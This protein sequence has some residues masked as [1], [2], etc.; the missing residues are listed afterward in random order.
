MGEHDDLLPDFIAECAEAIDAFDAELLL[1]EKEPH[2]HELLNSIFRRVH[3]IKGMCGFLHLHNLEALTHAAEDLL[4]DLRDGTVQFDAT[5]INL[6]LKTG[7]SIRRILAHVQNTSREGENT[8]QPLIESLRLLSPRAQTHV[9]DSAVSSPVSQAPSTSTPSTSP[10]TTAARAEFS[11]TSLRVD[12]A[13]LDHLMNLAGELVLARNQLLQTTKL[14]D[15]SSFRTIVQR[16]HVVTSELQEGVMKTR[17]QPLSSL[18]DRFPRVA[19]D[20]AQTLNKSVQLTLS[21]EHTEVDKSILEALKDPLVHLLRNAIDHGI[22]TPEVRVLRDKPS[23]G[24]ISLRAYPDGGYVIIEVSDDGAGLDTGKI[25]EQ[26]IARGLLDRKQAAAMS[27]SQIQ[28]YIFAP[29]FSTAATVTNLSGR[30]VGMDIVRSHIESISGQIQ[31]A[32][33]PGRGTTVRL[34]IPLSL[35][36]IPTLLVSCAEE[37]FAIPEAA[38]TELVKVTP[39]QKAVQIVSA[40]GSTFLRVRQE[41]LPLLS[42]SDYLGLRSAVGPTDNS[43]VIIVCVEGCRFGVVVDSVHNIEEIVVK[44]LN[45]QLQALQLFGGATI[46]GGGRI[47]LIIDPPGMLQHLRLIRP[48][49]IDSHEPGLLDP[50]AQSSSSRDA[51]LLV[52]TDAS[53]CGAIPLHYVQRIEKVPVSALERVDATDV[54]QYRGKLLPII[55]HLTPHRWSQTNPHEM[56]IVVLSNPAGQS[57]GLH[58]HDI[59]DICEHFEETSTIERG[60]PEQ[61]TLGIIA[62]RATL[63]IDVPSLFASVYAPRSLSSVENAEEQR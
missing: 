16:L 48:D 60:V 25:K 35:S 27:D 58:V 41:L 62:E 4:G 45:Q 15:D 6:L 13:L 3:S 2:N 39:Q 49:D 28:R 18:W 38:V 32:S 46:L 12:I 56:S 43:L 53:G 20:I 19:R 30:G 52:D 36:I 11:E 47:V 5:I 10:S 23:Q 7:D 22:E 57:I 63:L 8:H 61:H 55:C 29:G 24:K 17:V 50:A 14:I 34:K 59:I 37:T 42:L 54:I 33:D 40:G 21:G 31:I 51:Y 26:A 9:P 44:P 1:L